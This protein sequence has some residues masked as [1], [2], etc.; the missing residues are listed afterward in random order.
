MIQVFGSR[1]PFS[2]IFGSMGNGGGM[3]GLPEDLFGPSF[4]RGMPM[5]GMGG[6]GSMPGA[7]FGTSWFL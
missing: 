1:S 5:G 7:N 4:G 6:F 2:N 3:G